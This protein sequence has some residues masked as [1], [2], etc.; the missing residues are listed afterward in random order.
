V[1][2]NNHPTPFAGGYVC[3]SP[4]QRLVVWISAPAVA[5]S[6]TSFGTLVWKETGKPGN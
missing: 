2:G 4:S 3:L 6:L 1:A 5:V